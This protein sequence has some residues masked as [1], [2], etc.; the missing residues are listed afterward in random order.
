[1]TG[2]STAGKA[3]DGGGPVSEY[4]D[5]GVNRLFVTACERAMVYRLNVLC[6][7]GAWKAVLIVVLSKP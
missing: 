4:S 3:K 1:M 7:S 6:T 2:R 5:T